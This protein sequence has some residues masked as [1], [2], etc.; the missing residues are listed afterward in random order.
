MLTGIQMLVVVLSSGF[1]YFLLK[2]LF[3][4]YLLERSCGILANRLQAKLKKTFT[5]KVPTLNFT[6]GM[7]LNNVVYCV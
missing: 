3:S 5:L 2:S 1:I 7:Y 4:I 6:S